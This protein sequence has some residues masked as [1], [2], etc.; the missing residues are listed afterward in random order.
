MSRTKIKSPGRPIELLTPELRAEFKV[1]YPGTDNDVLM[2]I[3]DLTR[4]QV[5]YLAEKLSVKK[6]NFVW[7]Q[8]DKQFVIDNYFTRPRL[9]SA[10]KIA[11]KLDKPYW[12]VVEM[13]RKLKKAGTVRKQL[14]TNIVNQ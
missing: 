9:M 4:N 10:V 11:D 3:F 12:G 1:L 13:I 2:Y 7:K 6:A 8:K 5:L 14:N